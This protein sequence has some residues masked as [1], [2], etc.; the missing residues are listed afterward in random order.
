VARKC[1]ETSNEIKNVAAQMNC[2]LDG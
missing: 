1:N 2:G